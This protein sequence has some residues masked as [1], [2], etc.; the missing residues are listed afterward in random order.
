MNTTDLWIL[1]YIW[2]TEEQQEVLTEIVQDFVDKSEAELLPTAH[3]RSRGDDRPDPE[4][5]GRDLARIGE[6]LAQS[7]LSTTER[8]YLKDQL[9]ILSGRC[10]WVEERQQREYLLQQVSNLW[11]PAGAKP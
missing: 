8:A 7:E 3:P 5:L 11:Q 6:R 4:K 2:D 10:Q 9:G 1:R